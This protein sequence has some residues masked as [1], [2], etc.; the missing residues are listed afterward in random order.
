MLDSFNFLRIP[1]FKVVHPEPEAVELD[2]VV[3]AFERGY[4]RDEEHQALEFLQSLK[5]FLAAT[6]A[7]EGEDVNDEWIPHQEKGH[8]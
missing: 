5:F 8:G 3:D 6:L 4:K 1:G 2:G 7:E